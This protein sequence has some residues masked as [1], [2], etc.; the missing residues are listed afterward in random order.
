MLPCIF[1]IATCDDIIELMSHSGLL[2]KVQM[3]G[4]GGLLN[5]KLEIFKALSGMKSVSFCS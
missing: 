3:V 1:V 2:G 5:F 4:W